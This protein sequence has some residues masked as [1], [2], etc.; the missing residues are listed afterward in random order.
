MPRFVAIAEMPR[1]TEQQFRQ[2]FDAVKKWR[3]ERRSWVVKA[4]C[5]LSDGKLVVEC[6][7]AD[8]TS[9]EQWLKNTG[10]KVS[11]VYQVNLIHEAGSV[12][13]V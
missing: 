10:W 13:P 1:I 11:G 8:R 12:W 2:T 7:T 6:E 3:Y 9:F 5:S 4:Y